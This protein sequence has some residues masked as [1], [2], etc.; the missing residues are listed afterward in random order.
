MMFTSKKD[1]QAPTKNT[2]GSKRLPA[3]DLGL[4]IDPKTGTVMPAKAGK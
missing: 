3:R 2:F 1:K 4:R